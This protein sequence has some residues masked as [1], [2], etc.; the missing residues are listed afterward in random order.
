MI[1]I[2]IDKYES[3]HGVSVAGDTVLIE[4]ADDED[5]TAELVLSKDLVSRICELMPNEL[6]A[7]YVKAKR[8]A[9]AVAERR[10]AEAV[11]KMQEAMRRVLKAEGELELYVG[12]NRVEP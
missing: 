11:A 9:E 8:E 2:T 3:I 1:K 4:F 10:E 12:V 5:W 7:G 6:I